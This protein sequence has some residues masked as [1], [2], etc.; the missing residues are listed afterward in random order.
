MYGFHETAPELREHSIAEAVPL[1]ELDLDVNA[2]C[3]I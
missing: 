1:G 2:R 3:E